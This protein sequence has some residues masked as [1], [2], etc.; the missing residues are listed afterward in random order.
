MYSCPPLAACAVDALCTG[1]VEKHLPERGDDLCIQESGPVSVELTFFLSAR[2]DPTST[3][4]SSLPHKEIS[5]FLP[6][7]V[8]SLSILFLC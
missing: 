2:E 7:R 3:L 8:P 5:D 1:A 4:L 6:Q